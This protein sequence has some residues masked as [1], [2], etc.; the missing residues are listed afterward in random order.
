MRHTFKVF[1][2]E[3]KAKSWLNTPNRGLNNIKPIDLFYLS[4]GLGMVNDILGRIEHG[5]Y[6]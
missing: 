3:E 1:G 2:D 4:T 5:V 6:S